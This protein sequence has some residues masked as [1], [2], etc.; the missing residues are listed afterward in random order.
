MPADKYDLEDD[1][2]TWYSIREQAEYITTAV[3]AME[4]TIRILVV[5]LIAMGGTG[6]GLLT[7]TSLGGLVFWVVVGFLGGVALSQTI[8]HF[9]VGDKQQ[10]V[11]Y[12]LIRLT[13][14]EGVAFVQYITNEVGD[15][16]FVT[17]HVK[18]QM[19]NKWQ[20]EMSEG[21]HQKVAE[22]QQK[23]ANAK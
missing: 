17:E 13:P 21:I 2:D 5:A 20:G 11:Y 6:V 19:Y 10:L 16:R 15:E 4:V 7:T 14:R 23:E 18:S 8:L 9:A 22:R 3:R 1:Y 12:C